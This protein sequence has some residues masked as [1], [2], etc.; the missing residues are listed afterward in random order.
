[1][2][3]YETLRDKV[4]WY[5]LAVDSDVLAQYGYCPTPEV[6]HLLTVYREGSNATTEVESRYKNVLTLSPILYHYLVEKGTLF[7]SC[8]REEANKIQKLLASSDQCIVIKAGE[9]QQRVL[10]AEWTCIPVD[11]VSSNIHLFK[12]YTAKI[13]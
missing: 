4:K 13:D 8:G 12:T 3:D 10:W 9:P 7:V 1:M 5:G 11:Q 6:D 2:Q